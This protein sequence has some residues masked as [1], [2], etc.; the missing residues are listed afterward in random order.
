MKCRVDPNRCESHHRCTNLY[1]EVFEIGADNKAQ[2]K[3]D[4]VPEELEMDAQ[5]AANSCPAGAILVEY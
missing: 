2:A 3:A 4:I 5:S 1:P